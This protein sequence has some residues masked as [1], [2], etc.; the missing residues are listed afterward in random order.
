MLWRSLTAS[1]VRGGGADITESQTGAAM[2]GQKIQSKKGL[3]AGVAA[4][5]VL[6]L[7]LAAAW[8]LWPTPMPAPDAPA[9][10]VAKFMATDRFAK[11]PLEQRQPYLDAMQ[12]MSFADR[13]ALFQDPGITEEQRMAAWRNTMGRMMD[14]RAAAYFALTTKKERDAYLDRMIDE[15]EQM[16][17]RMASF[18]AAMGSGNNANAGNGQNAEPPRPRFSMPEMQKRM[19]ENRSPMQREQIANFISELQRRRTE[20]GLPEWRPGGR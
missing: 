4:V 17:A 6:G 19:V 5:V 13:M 7:G 9:I 12:K 11:L 10:E 8:A 16:R 3:I 1:A 15:G 18:R 2:T 14:D 20:R